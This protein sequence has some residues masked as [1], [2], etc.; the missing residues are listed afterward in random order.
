MN[1]FK[2]TNKL[3]C[4]EKLIKRREYRLKRIKDELVNGN[5]LDLGCRKGFLQSFLGENKKYCGID[6]I[7]YSRYVKNFIKMDLMNEVLPFNDNTF[8]N[9]VMGEFLEHLSNKDLILKETRRVLK[10]NGR[11]IVSVPNYHIN[12]CF[13]QLLYKNV[14]DKELTEH[15]CDYWECDLIN[16]FKMYGFKCV[17]I[18][19]LW[20]SFRFKGFYLKLPENRLFSPFATNILAV[21]EKEEEKANK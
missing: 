2:E 17:K 8:S 12:Q 11:V 19:R 14:K 4:N 5:V 16:L 20:N 18:E 13:T 1:K 3:G 7:D 15:V 9:I 10:R 6:F 21:F